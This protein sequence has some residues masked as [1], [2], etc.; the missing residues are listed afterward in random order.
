MIVGSAPERFV[1][2]GDSVTLGMGDPMPDGTWRGWAALLGHALEGTEFVNLAEA[3]ALSYTL[4]DRQLPQALE[5]RPRVAAVMVGLNDTLRGSFDVARTGLSIDRAVR[6]LRAAGATVLTARLPDPG[7]MLGLP[8]SLAR[9]LARRARAVND[10]WDV[11]AARHDTMHVDLGALP[12][13][14]D[15][16]TW[17]VDRLHPSERGHRLVARTFA[18][19]LAAAGFPITALP[20]AEPCNPPPTRAG[21]V[22]WMATKGVKWIIDRSTDLLPSLLGLAWREWSAQLRGW[23]ARL[24]LKLQAEVERAVDQL[25]GRDLNAI[26]DF[27]PQVDLAEPRSKITEPVGRQR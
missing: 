8:R 22:C 23:P 17:S 24:D 25:L 5:L 12:E 7:M 4:V 10:M 27:G 20:G 19:R 11:V 26:V 21:S 16:G 13:A 2:L 14:Y 3:G 1:A 15:R 6:E 9:P 18:R